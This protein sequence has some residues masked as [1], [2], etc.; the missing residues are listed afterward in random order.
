MMIKCRINA[1]YNFPAMA[2]LYDGIENDEPFTVAREE[3]DIKI[4][5]DS[6]LRQQIGLPLLA[7]LS[8][9]CKDPRPEVRRRIS[10]GFY[11]VA[12]RLKDVDAE[13]N[14]ASSSSSKNATSDS[15]HSKASLFDSLTYLL[16]DES[17]AVLKSLVKHLDRTL[18]LLADSYLGPEGSFHDFDDDEED[19]DQDE[20]EDRE[21]IRDAGRLQLRQM[22]FAGLVQCEETVYDSYDWRLQAEVFEK[23]ARILPLWFSSDQIF[24]NVVPFMFDK[25]KDS[26]PLP[27]KENRLGA[28]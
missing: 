25:I 18:D 4:K 14:A 8:T 20:D 26:R 6:P 27:G 2:L 28:G 3:K 10:S 21:K 16:F 5:S 15:L 19:D 1:A 9:L 13:T 11:E 17:L 23:W 12:I 24:F 7:S 22:L